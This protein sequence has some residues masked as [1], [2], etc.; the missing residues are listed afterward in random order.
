MAAFVRTT[1]INS[2]AMDAI[3]ILMEAIVTQFFL[4]I[5]MKMKMEQAIPAPLGSGHA[6]VYCLNVLGH[7]AKANLK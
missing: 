1:K 2:Y 6:G 5:D 7:V 4:Q 3:N